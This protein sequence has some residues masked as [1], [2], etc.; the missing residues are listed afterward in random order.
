MLFASSQCLDECNISFRRKVNRVYHLRNM[1]KCLIPIFSKVQIHSAIIS[2]D[3]NTITKDDTETREQNWYRFKY[4]RNRFASRYA[5][6][7]YKLDN[8]KIKELSINYQKTFE[9]MNMKNGDKW[10]SLYYEL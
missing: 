3:M 6:N 7:L 8:N 2:E 9:K 1:K 4:P 10:K 5:K